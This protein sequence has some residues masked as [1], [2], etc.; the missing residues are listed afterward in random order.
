[1]AYRPKEEK[2]LKDLLV[3]Q[4]QLGVENEWYDRDD[5]LKIIPTLNPNGLIGGT[6]SPGDGSA[7]PMLSALAFERR[8]K[9]HGAEY[10]YHESVTGFQRQ[11]GTITGVITDKG[12]YTAQ[13]VVNAAECFPSEW[14]HSR[15]A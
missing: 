6:F 12:S 9:A 13:V 7:S 14:G 11:D 15:Q 1:M 8:A 3:L 10:H 4:K 2:T 5:F